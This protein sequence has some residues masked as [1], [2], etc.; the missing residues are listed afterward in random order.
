[1]L[2]AHEVTIVIINKDKTDRLAI[3]SRTLALIRQLQ[4]FSIALS[5]GL[6]PFLVLG[7]LPT[8]S[9]QFRFREGK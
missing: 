8:F 1:M 9:V 3:V 4:R 6:T 2:K 5:E 7:K